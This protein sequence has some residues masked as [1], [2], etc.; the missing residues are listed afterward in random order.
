MQEKDIVCE[1]QDGKARVYDDKKKSCYTV[2]LTGV[3]H[4]VSDSAYPRNPD[5]LSIATARAKYL[6]K[7]ITPQSS[8]VS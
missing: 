5:G 3:T 1:A 7:R 8:R 4:S 6:D 2:F